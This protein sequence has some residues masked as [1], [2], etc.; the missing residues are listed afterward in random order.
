[1]SPRKSLLAFSLQYKS[2]IMEPA[3]GSRGGS[4]CNEILTVSTEFRE[5]RLMSGDWLESCLLR[6][7]DGQGH[8]GQSSSPPTP[9]IALTVSD[10]Y[11]RS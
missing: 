10:E 11:D 5:F 8:H 3:D 9:S 2:G 6:R 7:G 4:I 1:M